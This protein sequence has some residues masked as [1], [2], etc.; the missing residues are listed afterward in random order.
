MDKDAITVA[1]VTELVAEQFPQWADLPVLPVALDGW[2]NTTFRL[3]DALS[4]RLPSHDRYVPEVEKEHRWLPV[5]GPRLP[6]PIPEPVALG[7]PSGVFPRPWSIYRWI[8]GNPALAGEV[9]DL[10][11]FAHDLGRFLDAL[12][13]VDASN[14]PPHGEH[15]FFRGGPLDPLD[16]PSRESIAAVADEIDP[17]EATEAW[18][19]ALATSWTRPAVW[20]HGDV[21]PSNLLV[22]SGQLSAVID[23]GCAAVGDPACDLAMAWTYFSDES[24]AVFRST[25]GLDEATWARA[26]GWALWKALVHLAVE[27]RGGQHSDVV[28]RRFGWRFSARDVVAAILGDHRAS[29]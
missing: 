20:V 18:E 9:T 5:L 7:R 22:R 26:R 16:A 29:T 25:L 2:D 6:L 24:T 10:G 14:G 1:V 21:A 27:K 12:Y 13:A 28:V 15:S 3:G 4:V 11:T 23:F 19:A 8:E 17:H